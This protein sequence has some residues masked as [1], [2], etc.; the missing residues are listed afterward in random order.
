M[1]KRLLLCILVCILLLS[2]TLLSA[3]EYKAAVKQLPTTDFFTKLLKA[4]VEATGNT[5]NIQVV[6][7]ARADYLVSTNDVDLQLPMIA[8]PDV[9]KQQLLKYDYS[10]VMLYKNSWV[11]Y[12]KKDKKIDIDSLRKA[13]PNKYKIEIDPSRTDDFDYPVI[14]SSNY[15]ASFNKI[16]SGA[17]DGLILSQT[18]GDPILIK[19]GLKTIKRQFWADF[20]Q[21]FSIQKGTRGGEVDKM[22]TDGVNKLKANGTFDKIAGDFIKAAKYSDW[23]P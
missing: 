6:P 14:P 22:L 17:I 15:D 12:T 2:F 21:C 8:I 19:S 11:I 23:Q 20:D 1:R 10:T 3:K 13:N 16:D 4:V 18:T 5:V 9:K 7:P